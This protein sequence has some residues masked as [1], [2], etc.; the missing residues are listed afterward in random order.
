MSALCFLVL[1][2][3]VIV[4]EHYPSIESHNN[5]HYTASD[6]LYTTV[7]EPSDIEAALEALVREKLDELEALR[8][9]DAPGKW[10]SMTFIKRRQILTYME[11]NI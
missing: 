1:L 8:P 5:V 3:V 11:F 2:Q 7:S 4:S 6:T 9:S 10:W